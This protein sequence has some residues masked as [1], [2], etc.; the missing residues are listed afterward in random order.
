MNR[1]ERRAMQRVH[2]TSKR[3]FS[4]L[5][6]AQLDER[7]LAIR[8]FVSEIWR[9]REDCVAPR[10]SGSRE[11]AVFLIVTDGVR[12]LGNLM[13]IERD[14]ETGKPTLLPAKISEFEGTDNISPSMAAMLGLTR[15]R[16][17]ERRS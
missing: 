2:S 12:L 1:H 7:K 3:E 4:T 16:T 5:P 6:A 9:S 13:M 10:E 11:E 17:S 15:F 8:V 14:W